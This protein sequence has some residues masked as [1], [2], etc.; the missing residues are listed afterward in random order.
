MAE[1]KNPKKVLK[2]KRN[3]SLNIGTV[4]FGIVFLYMIICVIMYLTS[5][6]IAPYEV[7]E[8]TLSGNYKYT[9]LA[10]RSE[11]LVEAPE[12]GSVTYY[13]REGEQI[14]MNAAVC[15]INEGELLNGTEETVSSEDSA[16]QTDTTKESSANDASAQSFSEED[17]AK[18]RSAMSVY[19]ANFS[20]EDFQQVYEMKSD[21]ESVILD[22]MTGEEEYG[23][24]TIT[25]NGLLSLCRAPQ[26][27][28][29]V[30]SV[31]GYEQ[32]Q[33]TDVTSD[34]FDK[35]SYS[36]EN[37]RE[38]A[39]ASRGDPLYKLITDEV[40][41]LVVPIDAKLA[42]ELTDESTL[43]IRFLKDGTTENAKVTVLSN[44]NAYYAQFQMNY[45]VVRFSSDRYLEIELLLN[46]KSG[47]KI[48]KSAIAEKTFYVIPEDYVIYD[49][50]NAHEIT[51]IKESYDNEGKVQTKYIT[52]TVYEKENDKYYV[53]SSLFSEGDYVIMKNSTNKYRI[54][55]T[56]MLQGVYNINKGYAVFREITILADNEEY[57]IV[58][59]DTTFGLSQY[60]H[61][62]LNAKTVTDE[63]ILY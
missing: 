48:P 15:S 49:E 29:V 27:G 35:R 47:L 60:D 2:Y 8:G 24:S 50:D 53:D 38:A 46:Q 7:I 14:G 9:A 18:L 41:Y 36:R 63:Q 33:P 25:D 39:S 5:S 58:E 31:D 12:A 56:A 23:Y 34:M 28:I 21:V 30:Y 55:E 37:L 13:A 6:H 61:I 19:S 3:F 17:A 45:S 62:A 11:V 32:V 57:C 1:H 40:W 16:F 10:L 54:E 22:I 4:L 43:K 52:A 44:D 26:E 59:K 20:G 51:L 42:S